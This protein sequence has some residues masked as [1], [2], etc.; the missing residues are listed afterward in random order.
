MQRTPRPEAA[1][2]NSPQ[3]RREKS[4]E[5]R[6]TQNGRRCGSYSDKTIMNVLVLYILTKDL[7][8]LF[9]GKIF[10]VD[11]QY[12][13]A[14]RL[15]ASIGLNL[16]ISWLKLRVCHVCLRSVFI[17]VHLRP[18]VL[19]AFCG[20]FSVSINHIKVHQIAPFVISEKCPEL[21]I[22]DIRVHTQGV[23]VVGEIEACH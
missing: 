13:L 17:S 22:G 16:L 3:R 23:E 5:R 15:K 7:N 14:Q 20:G 21:R 19:S 18:R 1:I 9:F 4:L 8:F 10:L 12:I 6:S 2:K 11:W